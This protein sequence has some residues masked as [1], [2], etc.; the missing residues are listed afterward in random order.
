M[1][2]VI[3]CLTTVVALVHSHG[4]LMDP[5]NRAS[6]WRYDSSAPINYDDSELWCGGLTVQH[7]TYGGKCGI[8]GDTYGNPR[9]RKHELGGGPFGE[10]VIVKTYPADSI[11]TVTVKVTVNHIGYF[12]FDLCKMDGKNREEEECFTK[13]LTAAGEEKWYVP[14]RESK[15]YEV[16]LKLPDIECEHCVLRWTYVAGNNWGQCEDG[17]HALGCGPQEH[18]RTC[19]DISIKG[20]FMSELVDEIPEQVEDNSI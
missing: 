4:M 11:I 9:P 10:G 16:Q 15:D 3:L 1:F 17:S 18:F 2:K 5:V 8:C 13:V 14:S 7:N 19:S 6:R 12:W 20:G